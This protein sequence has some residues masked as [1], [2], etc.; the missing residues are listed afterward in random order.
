VQRRT[1]LPGDR[2]RART[3]C[4]G[5]ETAPTV[6]LRVEERVG[7]GVGDPK[8]LARRGDFAR[9]PATERH[10]HMQW[11]PAFLLRDLQPE[12]LAFR[13]NEEERGALHVH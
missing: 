3:E 5:C 4:C 12:L 2:E 13:V 1:R 7:V 9:D 10:P 8:R 6:H 11:L